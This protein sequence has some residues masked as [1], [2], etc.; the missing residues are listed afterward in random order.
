MSAKVERKGAMAG[1]GGWRGRG[2]TQNA[3]QVE[4]GT[5]HE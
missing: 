1:G 4:V 3:G 5:Y 2:Q